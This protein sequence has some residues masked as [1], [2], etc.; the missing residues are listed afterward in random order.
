MAAF[1]GTSNALPRSRSDTK[2]LSPTADR[3]RSI[4][5]PKRYP[6]RLRHAGR[7]RREVPGPPYVTPCPEPPSAHGQ[8]APHAL[9][10]RIGAARPARSRAAAET[11]RRAQRGPRAPS[12]AAGGEVAPSS[13]GGLWGRRGGSRGCAE[14]THPWW[15]RR[16]GLLLLLPLLPEPPPPLGEA[17]ESR[18][19]SGA[20]RGER[21]S[22]AEAACGSAMSQGS[23]SGQGRLGD[24]PPARR[25]PAVPLP[26]PG[27]GG[28][29]RRRRCGAGPARPREGRGRRET[30]A[31][32]AGV[33]A[34]PRRLC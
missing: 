18:A 10:V 16:G 23:T 7:D 29:A 20:E 1:G 19:R 26:P 15:W 27:R 14:G 25:H 8:A 17:R 6:D 11:L 33:A 22:G 31:V 12:P 24:T 5:F 34:V 9:R 4:T 2:I 3:D 13:G 30:R 32:P 28:R 21:G